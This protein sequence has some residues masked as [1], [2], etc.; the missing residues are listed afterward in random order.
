MRTNK[1][2]KAGT[3]TTTTQAPPVNLVTRKITVATAVMIAPSPLI[4]ARRCQPVERWRHQWTTSPV[5]AQVKPVNTP[6]A[7]SGMSRIV[8]PS[9]AI[10]KSRR[11]DGELRRS[12]RRRSGGLRAARR[13]AAGSCRRRAGWRGPADLRTMCW[14]RG[15]ARAVIV[16]ETMK[17]SQWRP[18]AVAMIWLS[19]VWPERGPIFQ[20]LASQ[21]SPSSIVPRI[22]PN[23]SSVRFA[24]LD[25]RLF[26]KRH[27]VGDRLD[28]GE[29]AAAGRERLQ[30][31]ERRPPPRGRGSE[32]AIV[33]A[34][35]R[36]AP[37]GGSA[38]SG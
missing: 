4:A 36:D 6:M 34:G 10:S 31:E 30:D 1:A 33:R 19:T 8:S 16:S 13:R 7:N 18:T 37:A 29:R 23:N 21:A 14:R 28:A 3:A 9:T 32:A 5:W 35:E 24:A 15:R 11:K 25:A 26:E 17:Y 12:H 20:V 27:A 2:M 38:R 22:T